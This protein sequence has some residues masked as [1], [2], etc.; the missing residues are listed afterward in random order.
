[1]INQASLVIQIQ[2]SDLKDFW[3]LLIFICTYLSV[4]PDVETLQDDVEDERKEEDDWPEPL[5][6]E[7]TESQQQF[8]S[9]TCVFASW[10]LELCLFDGL[11]KIF[12]TL[13]PK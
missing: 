10:K 12:F 2:S 8:G 5:L 4:F 13:F 11:V 9:L 3:L 6:D 7:M 1:M